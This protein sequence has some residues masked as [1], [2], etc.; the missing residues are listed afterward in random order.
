[1]TQVYHLLK[2]GINNQLLAKIPEKHESSF[3]GHVYSINVLRFIFQ[4]CLVILAHFISLTFYLIAFFGNNYQ[5]IIII[6]HSFIIIATIFL[7]FFFNKLYSKNYFA[8]SFLERNISLIYPILFE[9]GELLVFIITPSYRIS[10]LVFLVAAPF[11]VGGIPVINQKRSFITLGVIHLIYALYLP[12]VIPLSFSGHIIFI[13]NVFLAFSCSFLISF[14]VY[15]RFVN[16]F[17]ADINELEAKEELFKINKQ[18]DIIAQHDQLTGIFNRWSFQKRMD[19]TWH[20]KTENPN[21]TITVMMIDIDFFKKFND[22]FGHKAGDSTL[23]KVTQT[24]AG[25]MPDGSIFARY[26]GEEFIAIAYNKNHQD[27]VDSAEHI[28]NKVLSL[29]IENPDN[30]VNAYLTVSIGLATGYVSQ[31]NSY[32]TLID[33]ADECLYMSKNTGRNKVIH[34]LNRPGAYRDINGIEANF[35]Q[36][37]EA[38]IISESYVQKALSNISADCTLIYDARQNAIEFSQSSIDLFDMPAKIINPSIGKFL[39]YINIVPEERARLFEQLDYAFKNKEAFLSLEFHIYTHDQRVLPVA[40]RARCIYYNNALT[41][42]YASFFSI[43]KIIEYNH[44]LKRRTMTNSVT[45]LPDRQKFHMDISNILEQENESGYLLFLDIKNFKEINQSF[46]H[47][48]GDKV[49]R[50]TGK[51]LSK[52]AHK[53]PPIYNYGIDQF[54]IIARNAGKNETLRLMENIHNYFHSNLLIKKGLDIKVN[55]ATAAIEYSSRNTQMDNLFIDLDIAMQMVKYNYNNG[56]KYSFF[57]EAD[58]SGFMSKID[59]NKRLRKAIGNNFAGFMLY[60]QP[61]ISSDG[62][63]CVGAEALLRWQDKNGEINLPDDIIPFLERSDLMAMVEKWIFNTVCEQCQQWINQ[64]IS[65]DFFIQINLSPAVIGR[66]SL[67][68]EIYMAVTNYNLNTRN[69][70][71]EIT[72]TASIL[73]IENVFHILQRLRQNGL[74]IAIDDFGRGYS[75]LSYLNSLPTDEVKIDRSFVV[76]IEADETKREFM[77]VIINLAKSMGFTVCVEGIE[78]YGQYQIL[79]QLNIDIIQGNYFAHPM[80]ADDFFSVY[81]TEY[82]KQR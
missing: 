40:A 10:S 61:I 52:I 4:C 17:I 42:I 59:L 23:V 35:P 15:S 47:N 44:F 14:T 76:G 13:K 12:A 45:L 11:I 72:E 67:F 32:D 21:D 3:N 18:L 69:I 66:A 19:E 41:I 9:L 82:N 1:M 60:Y 49:L 73:E 28:R 48:I 24:I 39:D 2:N 55:I 31:L 75:S 53:Y 70:I 68:E 20:A 29:Q 46:S 38:N 77:N 51:Y 6:G 8:N 33:W 36:T 30:R 22:R 54:L 26:G 7:F 63:K 25:E 79:N 57:N 71:L 62:R 56:L 27:M 78:T 58:R 16:N 80:R 34:T 50:E 37:Y 65:E 43:Q 5:Y 74:K 64:G 81:R